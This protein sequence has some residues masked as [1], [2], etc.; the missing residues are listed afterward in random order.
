MSDVAAPGD[1][2]PV[3]DMDSMLND[4][5]ENTPKDKNSHLQSACYIFR[6]KLR[7]IRCQRGLL[8]TDPDP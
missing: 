2:S 6:E 7:A 5:E 1:A 8:P 3:D 4:S